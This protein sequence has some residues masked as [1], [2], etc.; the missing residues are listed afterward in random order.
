[1]TILFSSHLLTLHCLKI[2]RTICQ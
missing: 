1:M 2:S